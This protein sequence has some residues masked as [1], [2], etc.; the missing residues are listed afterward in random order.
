LLF[1]SPTGAVERTIEDL[2]AT[3]ALVHNTLRSG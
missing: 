1:L 2:E 3:I